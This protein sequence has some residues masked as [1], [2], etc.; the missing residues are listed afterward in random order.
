MS[1]I[2]VASATAPAPR[3][4]APRCAAVTTASAASA[5]PVT[6]PMPPRIPRMGR[7]YAAPAAAA[8]DNRLTSR[9][10]SGRLPG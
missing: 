1:A 2:W 8:P 9:E 7:A 10:G 3:S 4:C 6:R 5:A